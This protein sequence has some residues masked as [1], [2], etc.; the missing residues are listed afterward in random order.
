MQNSVDH[1]FLVRNWS[2]R[3]V[4]SSDRH[5]VAGYWGASLD[6]IIYKP[7]ADASFS[8]QYLCPLTIWFLIEAIVLTCDL[9]FC[10]RRYLLIVTFSWHSSSHFWRQNVLLA[11]WNSSLLTVHMMT[12]ALMTCL[13]ERT[14]SFITWYAPFSCMSCSRASVTSPCFSKKHIKGDEI[15]EEKLPF[16]LEEPERRMWM[17]RSC[18]SFWKKPSLWT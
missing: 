12:L 18:L 17:R 2:T 6:A 15:M 9:R 1:R 7:V 10:L 16:S 14:Q 5:I 3:P 13:R 4:P 8:F 11:Q